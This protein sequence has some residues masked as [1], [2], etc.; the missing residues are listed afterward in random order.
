MR[1][2][3][4][5][6]LSQAGYEALSARDGKD[7]LKKMR[8]NCI[9]LVITDIVMPKKDGIKLIEELLQNHPDARIIAIS[10]G[11]RKWAEDTYLGHAKILG[12]DEV[13]AKPFRPKELLDTIAL[14]LNR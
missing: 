9:D 10:G 5:E 14:I 4:V 12:A 13:L 6:A 2:L 7:A 3:I 11:D 1:D 8:R